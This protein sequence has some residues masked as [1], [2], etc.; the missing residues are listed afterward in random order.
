MAYQLERGGIP[1][2]DAVALNGENG[3]TTDTMEQV[4]S[5]W[6]KGCRFDNRACVVLL[7]MTTPP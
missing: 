7:D 4:P 5:I 2:H 3:A 1:L 6:A